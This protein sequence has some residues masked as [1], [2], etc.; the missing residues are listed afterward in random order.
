[1]FSFLTNLFSAKN[2][3]VETRFPNVVVGK[4][5]EIEKH[6]NADRLQIALVDIGEQLRI[7]CGAPNI[8]V[9]QY[10]PVALVGA[11]L[12]N[13]IIMQKAVI[14]G[15]E[16]NGMICAEDELGLGNDHSGIIVFEKATIG[17]NID[18]Y[19]KK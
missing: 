9:G 4:I 2:K 12:P 19:L 17:D 6:P 11:Q 7:V 18:S 10:V 8:K 1:M 3:K 13:G 5:L 16:S 15:V 14:R